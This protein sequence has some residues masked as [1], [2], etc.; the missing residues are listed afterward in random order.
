MLAERILSKVV[1]SMN[2][3]YL[4]LK[5]IENHSL[6]APKQNTAY[7]LYM[8]V[9][10]CERLCPYCSF[11]RFPFQEEAAHKYFQNLRT[12]MK[13]LA[14]AGYN[15][16]SVYIGGGTPTILIDELCDTIN[17]AHEL[18]DI[19]EVSSETNPNHLTAQYIDKLN[20]LVQR[21]SV[22]VQSFDNSLLKQMDRF[23][24][25][26]SAEEILERVRATADSK[27]FTS[28]NVDMIFNFPAQTQDM[29]LHDLEVIKQTN[30]NQTTFYPLMASPAVEK[31]LKESV[32]IVD[33]KREEKFYKIIR[34]KLTGGDSPAFSMGSAWTFNANDQSMIDEYIVDYEE[35]PAIGSGGITFLDRKLFINTFSLG[36]YDKHIKNGELSL[37]GY[38][39]FSK[40]DHMRYRFMMQLFGL[41]LDKK[42]WKNDFDCSVA[43]GLP[44]EYLFMKMN[45]A[46]DTDDDDCITLSP[47]GQ[48]LLVAMMRQF[49]IGV[50]SVRDKA[51]AALPEDERALL[52]G[53]GVPCKN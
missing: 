51:R 32:G 11:N 10:F 7:M 45:G 13:M 52:F 29:L 48:Y 23:D 46:F 17:L 27:V 4:G 6:P 5:P 26:G 44:A 38:T 28:L 49:F 42:N 50:N 37:S 41:R 12:E 19:R 14:D 2:K 53:A 34:E 15:F 35:Y 21:L 1:R 24:K 39:Q 43:G 40:R 20:G 31:S 47:K 9:P 18:F 36:E 22:G 3:H 25:Y 8:H 16:N 33:Y 30:C